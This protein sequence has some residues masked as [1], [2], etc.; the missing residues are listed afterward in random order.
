MNIKASIYTL[1]LSI[2][3]FG[4]VLAQPASLQIGD[5]TTAENKT[6]EGKE[7][8]TDEL[9]FEA[10]TAHRHGDNATAA[11]LLTQFIAERPKVAA[12]HSEMARIHA[13]RKNMDAAM[14]SM[15]KAIALDTNNKWYQEIYAALLDS[16]KNYA[17]AADVYAQL[18][19]RDVRDKDYPGLAAEAYE[20]AGKK[21]EALKYLDI[22]LQRNMDDEE[23]MVRKLRLYLGMNKPEK[24]TEVV[25]QMI[26]NEP[27]NGEYYR[28]L[29]RLYDNNNMTAKATTL[30]EQALKKLPNDAFV[31]SG[32]AEHAL[33]MGDTTRYTT[34]IRKAI[35]NP[36]AETDVQ[37]DI[38]RDYIQGAPNPAAALADALPV[39]EQLAAQDPGDAAIQELNTSI[40]EYYGE[41]L[42]N[43]GKKDSAAIIYKRIVA[44]RPGTYD[45]W[46]HLLNVYLE[47]QYADSL[48]KYTE[49]AMRLFPNQAIVHF[50]NGLGYMNKDNNPAAIKAL[51][52]AI[53]L[54]PDNNKDA[55]A[56]MYSTLGDVYY[57][58]KQ[59]IRSDE[60]F[61]KAL[62]IDPANT[63]VLNN[64]SY[65]LS[66]R[67]LRL[68]DAEKMSK[69]ALELRPDE[70]TYLDT[71]GWIL[72][73]KGDLK[74][75]KVFIQKAIDIA[76]SNA[77]GTLYDHLGDVLYKLNEKD[78]AVEAW[79]KAKEKG[80]DD[81]NIDKKIGEGKLYE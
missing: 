66:E 45:A 43:S 11:T 49:K 71:Y 54:Q 53:D 24:A 10:I 28:L 29:G 18:S 34:Y 39:V 30:Y 56:A 14:Q 76:G 50:Y 37:V 5:T 19:R 69:R 58:A 27:R 13:E 73:K 4:S 38:L 41:T 25:E 60:A 23:L 31:Q 68:D 61:D 36:Y 70:G 65:Y 51:N 44:L 40:L 72:Y 81:K 17:G 16:A 59:Y 6:I 15:K 8:R 21:E 46:G 35:T 64:Y 48:I 3:P 80:T 20:K 63:N 74:Q 77:D 62:A 55:L 42:E 52:R 47:K 75:A 26:A 12:A 57:T 2:V 33:K 78:K 9:F 1:L 79:K 22:A 7:A 67:G 32:I